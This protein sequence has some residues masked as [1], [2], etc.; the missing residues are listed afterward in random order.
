MKNPLKNRPKKKK[1]SLGLQ[2]KLR[3]KAIKKVKSLFLPN[4]Q[5]IKIILIGSSVKGTF[6]KY[7]PPGFRGSLYSVLIL[8]L[9]LKTIIKFQN[10]LIKNQHVKLLEEI[11]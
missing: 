2:K 4:K 7:E 11:I 3:E 5:I 6:G 8:F 1:Y 9:L 10:G